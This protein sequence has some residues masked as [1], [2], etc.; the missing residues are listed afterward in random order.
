MKKIT[1]STTNTIEGAEIHKYIDVVFSNVVLGTN[2]FSDIGASFTD[3][4]GG[5]SDLYKGKLEMIRDLALKEVKE[6]AYNIGANA[7]LGMKIDFDEISGKGKS[8]F[9]ISLSG[10]AVKVIFN[11]KIKDDEY[12]KELKF[13]FEQVLN[14][15]VKRVVLS[16]IE[17]KILP[18]EQ[19]WK[20]L[21]NQP[22]IDVAIKLFPFYIAAVHKFEA[23]QTDS[24]QLLINNYNTLLQRVDSE[25]IANF[26]YNELNVSEYSK[27]IVQIINNYQFFYPEKIKQLIEN[28]RLKAAILCLNVK[29][30]FFSY[31]DLLIMKQLLDLLDK[32]PDTG[33]IEEAIGRFNSKKEMYICADGHKNKSDIKYCEVC[34]VDIKGLTRGDYKYIEQFRGKVISLEGLFENSI[35]KS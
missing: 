34:G 13:S 20:Y 9:M 1:I 19:Q 15:T 18:S 2:I 3:I 33:K 4:F 6:K 5:T 35:I 10:T 28:S 29:K 32:L 21:V 11:N 24:E 30:E 26:L 8:M 16:N 12:S 17:N 31:E 14:E 27:H 7:I 22:I 23:Q 25:L